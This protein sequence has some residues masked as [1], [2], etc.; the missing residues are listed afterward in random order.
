[1]ALIPLEFSSRLP[2]DTAVDRH[3]IHALLCVHAYHIDPLIRSDGFQWLVVINYRIIDWHRAQ[4]RRAAV[5]KLLTECLCVA[6]GAQIHDRLCAHGNG[7]LHLFELFIQIKAISGHAE[8]H[9]DL[10]A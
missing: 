1:M 6:E 4:H 9:I 8:V 2:V 5:H 3:K 10:R 7:R